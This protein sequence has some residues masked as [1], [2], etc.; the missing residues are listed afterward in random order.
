MSE[1]NLLQRAGISGLSAESC[2]GKKSGE[3]LKIK[4]SSIT[5]PTTIH[6]SPGSRYIVVGSPNERKAFLY[7]IMGKLVTIEGKIRFGGKLGYI[8]ESPWLS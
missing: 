6:I 1:V 7:A 5:L 8:P 2:V 3:K 4:K